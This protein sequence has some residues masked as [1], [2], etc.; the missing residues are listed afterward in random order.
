MRVSRWPFPVKRLPD[1]RALIN[2]GSSARVSPGWN[3]L[4][5]SWIVYLGRHRRLSALFHRFGLLHEDRYARIRQ[6]DR[7]TVCW[8]LSKGI[9]FADETFDGVYHCHL[10]EHIDRE[11]APHFLEECY[12]VLK[13]GGVLRIV[14][15][16]LERLARQYLD[17]VDRLPDRGTM[18]E[19]VHAVEEMIDQMV[20]RTPKFRKEQRL[21]V[22]L[23]EN[24]LIGDTARAGIVHRWMYDRFSLGQ[25][26]HEAGFVDIRQQ[27]ERTS[28]IANWADFNLD[29]GSDG[30]PHKPGSV[31]IEGIRPSNR[32]DLRA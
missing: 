10:L 32:I 4:D 6:M 20:E 8:D 21:I 3:N 27:D 16:D 13:G 24:V 31:Y 5:F 15:P 25:L 29:T 22:R 26:L 1:G 17:V 7:N 12:R 14:V 28:R 11:T 18:A 23:L 30:A 19:H 9:P 2:L